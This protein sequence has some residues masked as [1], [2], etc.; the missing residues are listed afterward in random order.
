MELP[1]SFKI[2]PPTTTLSIPIDVGVFVVIVGKQSDVCV[3]SW[4]L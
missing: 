1:P 4:E 2:S 3:G